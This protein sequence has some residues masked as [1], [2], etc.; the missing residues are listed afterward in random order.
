MDED[1][2]SS[3]TVVID[4]PD[5]ITCDNVSASSSNTSLHS[6]SNFIVYGTA[7]NCTVELNPSLDQN[8]TTTITVIVDDGM[9]SVSE[10]F[11]LTVDAVNDAPEASGFTVA[12]FEEQGVS[13]PSILFSNQFNDM[14]DGGSDGT[15][16]F[17]EFISLPT[18]GILF[19]DSNNNL[20]Q[21]GS[22][23]Q[24]TYPR[25]FSNAQLDDVVYISNTDYNGQDSFDFVLHD[26]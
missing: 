1:T 24:V 2:S 20:V 22:E 7:P 23:S 13:L 15:Y 25:T 12:A 6:N 8:G 4:D 18:Q 19:N 26:A 14:N 3:V 21:D 16:S 10:N 9:N 5:G 11:T 17:T